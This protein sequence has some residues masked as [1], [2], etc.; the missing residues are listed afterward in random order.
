MDA[1]GQHAGEGA[2]A[3][4][5]DEHEGE[6]ELVDR[7]QDVH[8]AAGRM[9]DDRMGRAVARAQEA[10]RDRD[11]DGEHGAPERDAEGHDALP[12]VLPDV[13]EGGAEVAAQE[14]RDV[15]G[16]AQELEG[17]ELDDPR[18]QAERHRQEQRDGQA[19]AGPGRMGRRHRRGA[20]EHGAQRAHD[21]SA[22]WGSPIASP[23]GAAGSAR[24]GTAPKIS[25]EDRG[26]ELPGAPVE[27]EPSARE[28]Q[29][30]IGVPS[31]RL[32]L[33]QR[34]HHREPGVG[35]DAAGACP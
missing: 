30:A 32:D 12:G 10:E 16:V 25:L 8:D 29:D 21:D 3:D 15:A 7:A 13:D 19:P 2:Q 9:I 1:E 26:A 11:R 33:V 31:R 18:G 27:D 20:A 24:S 35:G 5:G 6:H 28:A 4:G 34:G 23:S 14:G 22:H 17:A